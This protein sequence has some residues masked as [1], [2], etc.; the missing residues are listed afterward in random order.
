MALLIMILISVLKTEFTIKYI[1]HAFIIS[2]FLLALVPIVGIEVKGAKR[3][4]DLYFSRLQP[5]EILKPI[6][7]LFTVKIFL[8][9]EKLKTSQIKYVLS[10]IVLSSVIILL[11]DQPDLGQSILLIGSWVATVF[12][13]GVSLAYIFLIFFSLFY[14]FRFD[15]IFFTREVWI[16]N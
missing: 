1:L 9:L 10:F 14:F 12:I 11:I 4:L 16:C 3:W 8:T 15:I 13:Y 2:F 6:F 7:I 5:I